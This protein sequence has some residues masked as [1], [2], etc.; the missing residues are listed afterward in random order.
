MSELDDVMK[1]VV[2]QV[3]GAL[4]CAVADL[5]SG[6]LLGVAHHVPYFTQE[7]LEAVAAAAVEMF[8][9]PTVRHVEDL[10][11]AKRG[12]PS[13][14]LLEEMQMTTRYTIHFMMILPNHPEA[15]VVLITTRDTS[16]GLGWAATRGSVL[17]I[18]PILDRLEA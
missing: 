17:E 13:E 12:R 11:S 1:S 6:A 7:Y 2:Q 15:L 18:E 10:I 8:R 3:D 5:R 4:G 16:I 9:G 14:H